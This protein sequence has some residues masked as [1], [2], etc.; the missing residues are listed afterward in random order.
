[1]SEDSPQRHAHYVT[2]LT[3]TATPP[4]RAAAWVRL[5]VRS[6]ANAFAVELGLLIVAVHV[7]GFGR[8]AALPDLF[9]GS[10]VIA[11][12]GVAVVVLSQ[13]SRVR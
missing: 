7:L 3:G 1:M 8:V 2:P 5:A 4:V 13:Q 9:V 10:V 11:I 6:I 12:V